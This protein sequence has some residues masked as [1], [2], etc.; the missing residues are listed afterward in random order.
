MNPPLSKTTSV[1][2]LSIAFLAT[3]PPT[4]LA[5]SLFPPLAEKSFSKLE[6]ATKVTA[7]ISSM[8]CA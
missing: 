5:P 4:N 1:I 8:I 3:N 6:A 7:F 2:P